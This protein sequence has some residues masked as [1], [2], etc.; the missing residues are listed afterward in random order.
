MLGPAHCGHFTVLTERSDEILLTNPSRAQSQLESSVFVG[1][2][3]SFVITQAHQTDRKHQSVP[4]DF[5]N[6]PRCWMH[7]QAQKLECPALRQTLLKLTVRGHHF[8]R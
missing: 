5:R 3:Q 1:R 7:T 4:A 8:L 2:V 6:Q